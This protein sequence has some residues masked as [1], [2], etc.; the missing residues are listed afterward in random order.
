[1]HDNLIL[2]AGPSGLSYSLISN[3]QTLI[4]EKNSHP[5]GHASSYFING[6]TFDY[7]PHILFSKDKL[8]LDFIV[9]SLGDNVQKCK[10]KRSFFWFN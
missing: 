6:F 2:G 3:N 7:G 1:M 8:I 9:N 5:G 4:I 10:R